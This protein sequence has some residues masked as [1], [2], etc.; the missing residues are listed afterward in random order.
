[1]R[2]EHSAD[3]LPHAFHPLQTDVP[4]NADIGADGVSNRMRSLSP[5]LRMASKNVWK[6]KT[7]DMHREFGG[8][9]GRT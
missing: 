2:R 6:Q 5:P 1:M 4:F 8:D 3:A 7:P 9:P